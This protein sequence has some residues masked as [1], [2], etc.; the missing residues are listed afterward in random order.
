MLGNPRRR[1]NTDLLVKELAERVR[2][3]SDAEDLTG[4]LDTAVPGLMR[5]LA[6]TVNFASPARG[7]VQVLTLLLG[8]YWLRY[9]FLPGPQRQEDLQGCL[10]CS[11]ALA[12]VAPEQVPEPVRAALADRD[13]PAELTAAEAT[14]RGAVMFGNYQRTGNVQL[15][16]AA[17]GQFSH[18]AAVPA[19]YPGR[20]GYLSNLG[21][22]LRA[23]FE[24]TGGLADLEQAINRLTEFV[25]AAS[26]DHP[27]RAQALSNLGNAL[28]T[29]FGRTGQLADLDQAVTRLAEAVAATPAGHPNRPMYL[30]NLGLTLRTRFGRTGELADLEQAVTRLAEA[31]DAAP[32]DYP[33]RPGILSNLG[34]TLRTRFERTGQL[35]D[36]ER[37][38]TAGREAV[39][40]T[41]AGHP[42]QPMYLSNLGVALRARFERTGRLAD[43]DQ[44]VTVGREAVDATPADH[45][46]RV[47]WLSALGEAMQTRYG[48]TGE[49]A[50]LDQAITLHQAA[51]GATPADHPDR[52]GRVSRLGA[53]LRARFERTGRLADLDQ[54]VILHREASDAIPADDPDRAMYLSNLGNALLTRFGR[55]GQLT[56]LDQAITRLT[57]AADAIPADHPERPGMLS[58]LGNALHSRFGRTGQLTDLDQ[59]ITR[60]TEAADAIPADHPDRA[61]YL[62]NLGTSLR[63]RFGRTGQEADLNQAIARLAQAVDTT[64]QG[65]SRRPAMLSNLGNAL[66]SRF[67]R[68]GQLT[69]LEQAITGFSAAL[70]ATPAD[71]PDRARW[72]SNLGIA[73]RARS[74]RTGWQ[75]D[76]DRA[77]TVGREVVDASP[78][79][80][81]E[82]AKWLSN[83]GIA[84]WTRFGRTEE[85]Q[86]LDQAVTRLIEAVAASPADHPE[87][88]RYLSNLGTVLQTRFWRTGE[89]ADL[90]Q[91]VIRLSEAV[92]VTPADHP[93]RAAWL[94]TLGGALL[95]RSGRTRQ[96][97]D[98]DRAVA[99]FREG[100]GMVT[101]SPARRVVAARG[102]GQCALL[103]GNFEG[104]VEGYTAA[105]ELLPLAAWHGLDQATREHHL[106]ETAGLA[107]DAAAA[108]IAAGQPARAVELLEAGRSM[109]WTQA[110]HLRQ[111][112]A[113][114]RERAP[115]L[116]AVLEAARAVL[117][118]PVT[119]GGL[120]AVGDIDQVYAAEQRMLE[121]RRQAARDWDAAVDRV[122][123][124]EGFGHFLRPVPFADLRAAA[125]E[126]PVVFVNISRM[127]SHALV[128]T[129]DA[130]PGVLVVALPAAS[131]QTVTEQA[132]VLLGVLARA[133]DPAADWGAKEA[134]RHAVFN[135]LA[136]AWEAITEPVLTALGHART[137][138]GKVESWPRVWWCPTG[139]ATVLPLHAAGRHPRTTA[140]YTV[141]G[142]AAAV[143]DTVAGR[144]VSSYT[145][146]LSSL[147]N[148]ADR[149]APSRVR[150][151]AV[152][153]PEAPGY[154]PG[155]DPL[156]GV[157]VE[158][159]VVADYLP[160]P[161]H[162]TQLLGS[163]ATKRAVLEALPGH[164]W[165]HLSC[166][167]IQHPADASL[168]AFLLHDQ[169]LT[170]SD[171]AALNLR[172]T[173]LAYLAAC[174]TAAGDLRL[175]DEALHLAGALQLVGYCHVLA[176]LWSISDDAASAMAEIVYA[177][178][179]HSGAPASGAPGPGRPGAP[180]A[181]R[182]PYALHH[183]VT[184]LRQARPDEPLLWAPYIH[185]GP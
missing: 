176:T 143:A 86:D 166:H 7:D 51:L 120:D 111:D 80:H 141:M 67:E 132:D 181:A 124:I 118:R 74:E 112:L 61:M 135:V 10:R 64:P 168:S 142:E 44:A 96:Q 180:E 160:V 152:G 115:D 2:A 184:W 100:A 30:S 28:L 105:I 158:L 113:G 42:D 97:A 36:L 119:Y 16:Q 79:D 26:A 147:A 72:L 60:L 127:D 50:D 104:A 11:A 78:A 21:A 136:W 167:G 83:L 157:P 84:L 163:A 17:I 185:F 29:R 69:D 45:P 75:E 172:E 126:G 71:H 57:E 92:D 68:T 179:V 12:R 117:N 129:P 182:A 103:A 155:A 15:L 46:D 18:A 1:E 165:L 109:L 164:S 99:A 110:L 145:P 178:L 156:P 4:V 130:G 89:L 133:A 108:A 183:A 128:V 58:N 59:A 171:L 39:N 98:I 146:T 95:A 5:D 91:A 73:L 43:L 131:F 49:L 102:W 31:A 14:D 13:T 22:A 139:P 82:R 174:H 35:A 175:L 87:R 25:A 34:S 20:P 81:P 177:H 66:H 121:E 70:D 159:Q 38:I 76:L 3:V 134:G 93:D 114:L 24:R 8:V 85:Q 150:Q 53:A 161:E 154:L 63:A 173:D 140:N 116:A 90:D 144:V 106:R 47:K 162:A 94:S 122:R 27:D 40:A 55:T 169:P 65:H 153:V 23:R 170:L 138:T 48:R 56:D 101:A 33:H 148:A 137:P 62:S 123:R 151:L 6:E 37:V 32:A 149:A 9:Q 41:P 54:A 88:A 125:A 19:G 107:S 77:V 52:P